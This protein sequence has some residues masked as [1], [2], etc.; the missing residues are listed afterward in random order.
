MALQYSVAVN[1]ARL[2]AVETT[3]GASAKFE[4]RTGAP[5]ANCA[6]ADSGSLLISLSLD[7]SWMADAAAASKAKAGT[8]SGTATGA[9]V[10]GHFRLKDTTST[11]THIQGTVGEGSG[12][13][14]LDNTDI[15]IGQTVTINTFT[16]NAANT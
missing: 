8:W 14:S 2:D 11:T 12:D 7:A 13:L 1:N 15:G 10:A 4:I 5:P 16:L 6:A 9:G 3:A